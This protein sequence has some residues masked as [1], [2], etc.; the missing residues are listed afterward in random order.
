MNLEE[1][2]KDLEDLKKEYEVKKTGLIRNYIKSSA[3]YSVGD[4]IQDKYGNG[5]FI[6]VTVVRYHI[7]R[8]W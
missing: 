5:M 7:D 8:S 1:F 4:I 2:E 3:K 6:K